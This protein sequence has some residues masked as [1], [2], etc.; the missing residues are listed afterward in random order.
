MGPSV[1]WDDGWGIVIPAQA[2]TQ[3]LRLSMLASATRRWVPAFAGMTAPLLTLEEVVPAHA[4]IHLRFCGC[5]ESDV[6][7]T[8]SKWVPAFAGT[9][10]REPSS[11]RRPAHSVFRFR[12]LRVLQ[13]AGCRLSPGWRNTAIAWNLHCRETA[14]GDDHNFA[15]HLD[16][17]APQRVPMLIHMLVDRPSTPGVDNPD[18]ASSWPGQKFATHLD[19]LAAQGAGAVIHTVSHAL[20]TWRVDKRQPWN[21]G[22][23]DV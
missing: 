15:T 12:C 18:T 11:R 7:Q 8:R 5:S 19:R 14:I 21:T 17:L 20:S 2:G 10:A 23:P 4:G 16:S 13:V 22:R 3:C 1:R 9:T 6:Y